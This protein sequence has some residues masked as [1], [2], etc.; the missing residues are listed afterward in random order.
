MLPKLSLK[1]GLLLDSA[2]SGIASLLL[3]FMT[4]SIAEWMD[5][6]PVWLLR[7]IG[8]SFIGYCLLL[9]LGA[10]N[11]NLQRQI[12]WA[13]VSLNLTWVVLTTALLIADVFT[14]NTAGLWAVLIAN[15]LVLIF[16]A[17]QYWALRRQQP[18]LA[19]A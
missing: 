15:D 19:I 1:Q 18:V 8:L 3:I 5:F 13:A 6:E 2:L 14:L 9:D 12:G 17:F 11:Q 10:F 16:A 7:A 4:D